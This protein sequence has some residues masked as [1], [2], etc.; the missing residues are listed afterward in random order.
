MKNDGNELHLTTISSEVLGTLYMTLHETVE[1][2]SGEPRDQG[3]A[4]PLSAL[5]QALYEA[6]AKEL[7]ARIEGGRT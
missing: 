4:G 1:K 7:K 6:A 3:S 2:H 5:D